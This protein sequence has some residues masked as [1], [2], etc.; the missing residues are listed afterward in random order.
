MLEVY[1]AQI[2]FDKK[3]IDCDIVCLIIY[4]LQVILLKVSYTEDQRSSFE[5]FIS[6]A[7]PKASGISDNLCEI[8]RTVIN[9]CVA[10]YS[11]RSTA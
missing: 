6:L 3:R 1:S 9:S 5:E 8:F 11:K 4:V 10:R 2:P 7:D